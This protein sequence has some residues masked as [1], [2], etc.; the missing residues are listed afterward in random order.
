MGRPR[1]PTA[2]LRDKGAFAK[3]PKRGLARENEPKANGPIGNPPDY[4]DQTHQSVWHEF[5]D[6]APRGVLTKADRKLLELAVRLTC[7]MRF[8]PCRMAKWIRFLG[9]ALEQLGM[10]EDDVDEMNE[11]FETALGCTAQEA[12]LLAN[13]L[14]RMGLTPSD[15]SKVTVEP[16]KPESRFAGLVSALASAPR[17]N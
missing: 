6:E 8:E 9:K 15:R 10:P 4:F 16:E 7:K 17:P 3:D 2:V 12:S 5:V 1:K 14:Q 13:C 11:A